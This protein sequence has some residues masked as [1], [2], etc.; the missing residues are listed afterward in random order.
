MNRKIK[1]AQYGCGKMSVYLMRYVLEKGAELVAAFDMNPAVIGKDIGEIMGSDH[2]GIKVSDAKEADRI[3]GEQKPDVCIIATR[4]T[5]ID[6]KD[7][8][9]V[10]AKNGLTPFPP[11]RNPYIRGTHRTRLP[12]IWMRW[13]RRT[14]ARSAAAATR[15]CTGARWSRRLPVRSII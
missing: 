2:V 10:C 7:A 8:F 11:A 1:I 5:M 4:S 13:Q 14:T 6:V 9:T 15:I 3:L 12:K